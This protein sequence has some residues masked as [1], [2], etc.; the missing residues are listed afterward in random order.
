MKSE[1][2]AGE[3]QSRNMP[4]V[5]GLSTTDKK[6]LGRARRLLLQELASTA[7]GR[8]ILRQCQPDID[9][10]AG[11]I[12]ESIDSL[13]H[14]MASPDVGRSAAAVAATWDIQKTS[15]AAATSDR[16][17]PQTRLFGLARSGHAAMD[18]WLRTWNTGLYRWRRVADLWGWIGNLFTL[19]SAILVFAGYLTL[20]G[21]LIAIR[22][23]VTAVCWMLISFPGDDSPDTP[24]LDSDP[25]LT[26]LGHAGDMTL[27][28]GV[29]LWLISG[30]H[31][32]AGLVVWAASML[33]ILG[34]VFRIV[35][36][37]PRLHLERMMRGGSI[38]L[39]VFLLSWSWES[40]VFGIVIGP[41]GF[42]IIEAWEAWKAM[43][44]GNTGPKGAM[45]A[46]NLPRPG[47]DDRGER[48]AWDLSGSRL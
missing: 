41:I 27:M 25:R 28:F 2:A 3:S 42:A 40:A 6:E 4:K 35:S 12:S 26:V 32:P 16:Y 10:M 15:V 11:A 38:C 47:T 43:S 5:S 39:A 44:D 1:L 21:A 29:A 20:G 9:I 17:T 36:G 45:N 30:E 18:N 19:V 31:V 24:V 34:T 13:A 46:V 7:D 23:A 22:I 33:M 8:S 14:E 37:A 48:G